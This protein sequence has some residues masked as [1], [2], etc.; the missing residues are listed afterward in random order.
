LKIQFVLLTSS[1]IVAAALQA[2][3]FMLLSRSVSVAAFGWVGIASSLAAF[4]LLVSDMGLTASVSRARARGNEDVVRG[5]LRVNDVISAVVGVVLAG[6]VA[7]LSRDLLALGVL[8][9]ALSLERNAETQLSVFYADGDRL[10]PAAS[11]VGRRA[12]SL[13][14]FILLLG[15]GTDGLWAFCWAQLLGTLFSQAFQRFLLYRRRIPVLAAGARDVLRVAWPF[16]ISSV[17]NQVRLLDT[18]L[19]GALGTAASAGMYSAAMRIVNP[20]MLI[21][22]SVSQVLLPHAS[23]ATTDTVKVAY[24]V[25]GLFMLSFVAIVPAVLLSADILALL[26]GE[27]YASAAPVLAWSLCGLPFVALAGPLAAILQARGDERFVAL[28]GGAFA[29]IAIGAMIAGGI[30]ADGTG[31]AAGLAVVSAARVPVLL[32][33]ITRSSRA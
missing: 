1:R 7:L 32:V 14:A 10:A 11:I 29:V 17:L 4:I 21:P 27:P 22:A 3:G 26:F 30:V 5:A 31:V 15:T 8:V 16:W 18:T 23:K 28:N 13:G 9:L 6:T 12:I 25:T 33:R 2:I 20:L 24:R 19:V